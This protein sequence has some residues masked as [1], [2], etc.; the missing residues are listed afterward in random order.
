MSTD[1]QNP[2]VPAVPAVLPVNAV[3]AN[4]EAP[5][6]TV[7]Q[8]QQLAEQ[9]RADLAR[10]TAILPPLED[11]VTVS[12][13]KSHLNVRRVFLDTVIASVERHSELQAVGRLNVASARE[14]LQYIDAFRA[15]LD[16]VM[17][18]AGRVTLTIQS[19]QADV[20]RE[21]LQ[22]YDIAKGLERDGRNPELTVSVANMKRDLGRR[23][24]IVGSIAVRKAASEAARVARQSVL[25]AAS[26]A[27]EGKAA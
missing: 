5:M 21:A 24:P 15:V 19:R 10:V 16:D 12:S 7:T 26:V 9:F 8:Y 14:A 6:L 22:I 3:T 27:S 17:A 13:V 1:P 18:F 23:G 20:T 2:A 4:A 11:N 25:D